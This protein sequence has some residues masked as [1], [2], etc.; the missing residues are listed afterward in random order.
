MAVQIRDG[1]QQQRRSIA[2]Q[3]LWGTGKGLFNATLGLPL[4]AI[5]LTYLSY[6]GLKKLTLDHIREAYRNPM[7]TTQN[8]ASK[9]F[10]DVLR[11]AASDFV[12]RLYRMPVEVVV[13]FGVGLGTTR[14][15][16]NWLFPNPEGFIRS[17]SSSTQTIQTIDL[18]SQHQTVKTLFGEIQDLINGNG[19]IDPN[20]VGKEAISKSGMQKLQ[21]LIQRV[22]AKAAEITEVTAGK[23]NPGNLMTF[24][25]EIH[26]NAG[27][28]Q[29]KMIG[30]YTDPLTGVFKLLFK[31]P[32][33]NLDTITHYI[34]HINRELSSVTLF[35]KVVKI[36]Q[37]RLVNFAGRDLAEIGSNSLLGKLI[38]TVNLQAL[39]PNRD[40]AILALQGREGQ[41]LLVE[42]P[43]QDNNQVGG[44]DVLG[45][46]EEGNDQPQFDPFMREGGEGGVLVVVQENPFLIKESKEDFVVAENAQPEVAVSTANTVVPTARKVN[47]LLEIKI[48]K[49]EGH[50]LRLGKNIPSHGGKRARAKKHA[51]SVQIREAK[52]RLKA[53]R[54]MN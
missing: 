51:L 45:V 20:K 30:R 25:K 4:T 32:E 1:D 40:R 47:T 43:P 38:H 28:A 42:L 10:N 3:I 24:L 34:E 23:V 26:V 52:E 13:E 54:A 27:L 8:L 22:G 31:H 12:T 50:L 49:A 41:Q 7:E 36:M 17:S 21:D 44:R 46:G 16:S 35:R 6:R 37:E 53:L 9:A 11:P 14:V 39:F 33:R 5:G 2:E 29:D 15:L 48:E 19:L 18:S